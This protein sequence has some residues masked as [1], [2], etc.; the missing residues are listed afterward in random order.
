MECFI[1]KA[2]RKE[3]LY[4]YVCRKGDFSEIPEALLKS[5]G[6]PIYVMPLELTP[7]RT[8]AREDPVEVRKNLTDKGFHV[9]LPPV[10]L[11]APMSLQ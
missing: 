11:S 4:L 3:A 7:D 5:I 2:S 6:E 9:Q 8:L 1:Y 10:Q